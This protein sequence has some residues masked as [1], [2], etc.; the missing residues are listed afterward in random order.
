MQQ[1]AK[2]L[3]QA[4]QWLVACHGPLEAGRGCR[5]R[6]KYTMQKELGRHLGW[7]RSGPEKTN[8]QRTAN[9]LLAVA[10]MEAG[11]WQQQKET[12][13][14]A[15]EPGPRVAMRG[16]WGNSRGPACARRC[17]NEILSIAAMLSVPNVF[18]RPREAAKAADE[19]KLR[20][21]HIDG[22]L[23]PSFPPLL[24]CSPRRASLMRLRSEKDMIFSLLLQQTAARSV[25]VA[26]GSLDGTH[27][28][29]P[30]IGFHGGCVLP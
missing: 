14:L 30:A 17:S 7:R 10:Q 6:I 28:S 25:C 5:G 11:H 4:M 13:D 15:S 26:L 9:W 29:Q 1:R 24:A 3:G 27:V 20:F 21:A 19:A 16:R 18:M 8:M 23:P 22:A 12:C 2:T